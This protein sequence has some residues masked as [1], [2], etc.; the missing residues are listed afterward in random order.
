LVVEGLRPA[1]EFNHRIE[2]GSMWHKAEE[3][4]CDIGCGNWQEP[5]RNYASSLC[6]KYKGQQEQVQH[7]FRVLQ[8]QFPVYR[9]YWAKHNT[10]KNRKSLLQEETFCVPYELPSGR[11]VKLRGR[12]D[13]VDLLG[14]GKKAGIYLWE[15]KT[16]GDI[17]EELLRRQLESGFDLQT[18]LYLVALRQY[19]DENR[20]Q[21]AP[22]RGIIYNVVR[23]PLSGGK[24][25]IRQHKPTKKNPSGESSG[26]YYKRLGG[27]IAEEPEH[28]FMRWKVEVSPQDVER[29]RR[30]FLDPILEQLCDWWHWV[31]IGNPWGNAG[32]YMYGTHYR[33]PFGFYNALAE[34][35]SSELDE[36][37]RTGSEMGLERTTRLFPELD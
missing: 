11:V 13:S 8:A 19:A 6:K 15:N 4:W 37:L 23:R 7:W 9:D 27:L 18:M 14:K 12:W 17:K 22:T 24:H 36:Y 30:E 21:Y 34:G 32:A 25:S 2:Y 26:E 35:G 16:K 33:T 20:G 28:Y 3:S 5:V 10:I 31:T 1:D 29:F